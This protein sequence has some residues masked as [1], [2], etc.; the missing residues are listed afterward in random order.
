MNDRPRRTSLILLVAS[1]ASSVALCLPVLNVSLVSDDWV[2]LDAVVHKG[3]WGAWGGGGHEMLGFFRPLVTL[4]LWANY[5]IGGLNP[6]GYHLFN[7]IVH[8][9]CAWLV[10]VIV[11]LLLGD[12]AVRSREPGLVPVIAALIFL[13]HPSHG[14]PVAWVSGRGD[15]MACMLSLAAVAMW[16]QSPGIFNRVCAGLLFIPA[17]LAKE[18]AIVLPAILFAFEFVIEGRGKGGERFG[19]A[20]RRTWPFFLILIIFILIRS[21][22][23]G[24]AVGGYGWDRIV[25]MNPALWA[26]N[27]VAAT[28]RS[29]LPA[30]TPINVVISAFAM[31]AFVFVLRIRPGRAFVPEA[32]NVGSKPRP[33][34]YLF[35]SSAFLVSL[36][37]VLNLPISL[38]NSEGERFIYLATAFTAMGMAM[39]LGNLTR[40][41]VIAIRFIMISYCIFLMISLN[42]WREAGGLAG[43]LIGDLQ[44]ISEP[45]YIGELDVYYLPD[46][47]RGAYVFRNGFVEAA[48]LNGITPDEI[49]EIKVRNVMPIRFLRYTLSAE[50]VPAKPGV[51]SVYYSA[52]ELHAISH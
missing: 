51:V 22:V 10:G 7:A 16:I 15:L 17:L 3:A 43:K 33:R 26:R 8:G 14:E 39:I 28:A 47:L 38:R 4:T 24:Q 52:G 49:K 29:F 34:L 44:R 45:S 25:A 6:L 30:I 2:L 19:P 13:V 18:S 11:W 35:L 23:L 20:V 41:R 12:S 1:I 50:A 31:S 32:A 21:A 40:R 5:Q 42:T 46:H 27:L 37:P 48:R 36:V 9:V